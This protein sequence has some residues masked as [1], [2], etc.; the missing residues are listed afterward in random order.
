MQDELIRVEVLDRKEVE[1]KKL[2]TAFRYA[3]TGGFDQQ[4]ANGYGDDW[5]NIAAMSR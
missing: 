5:T 4:E 2:M 3:L 1:K